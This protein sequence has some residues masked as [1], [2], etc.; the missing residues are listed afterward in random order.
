MDLDQD[1][2]RKFL[3]VA[4]DLNFSRAADRLHISRPAVS[5]AIRKLEEDLGSQLFERDHRGVSLTSF[6]RT[7]VDVAH[8][9]VGQHN[10]A[11][12]A[13]RRAAQSEGR[14]LRVGYSPFADLAL[15]SAV[16]TRGSHIV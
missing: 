3:A 4:E 9:L 15:V 5:Q 14:L 10:E 1:L 13:A 8:T 7:F 2:L 6:G 16:H 11:V 12:A